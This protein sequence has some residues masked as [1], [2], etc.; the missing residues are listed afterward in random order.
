MVRAGARLAVDSRASKAAVLSILAAAL[1]RFEHDEALN[2]LMAS[3]LAD[4][5]N[6]PSTAAA[7]CRA[8]LRANPASI[9]AAALLS[10]IEQ[11][12]LARRAHVA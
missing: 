2:V 4:Q 6:E 1:Q 8:A 9:D 10:R 5:G 7:Y 3:Y 12:L 11:L